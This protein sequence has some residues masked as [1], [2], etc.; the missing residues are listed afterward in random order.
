[1]GL[2]LAL[3]GVIIILGLFLD[4]CVGVLQRGKRAYLREQ[5]QTEETLGLHGASYRAL[6]IS[7]NWGDEVLPSSVFQGLTSASNGYHSV[8]LGGADAEGK[9]DGGIIVSKRHE[10]HRDTVV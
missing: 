1:M 5:W 2:I 6:G 9:S 7:T 3:G 8:P 4:S 10:S